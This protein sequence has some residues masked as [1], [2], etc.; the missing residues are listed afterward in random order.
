MGVKQCELFQR[1]KAAFCEQNP[2][3]YD[4]LTNVIVKVKVVQE[5]PV[6]FKGRSLEADKILRDTKAMLPTISQKALIFR[7]DQMLRPF[8]Q[9]PKVPDE[10]KKEIA[11]FINSVGSGGSS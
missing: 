5:T 4:G 1:M 3:I 11:D 7:C 8:L 9:D 2:E 10:Q 6:T